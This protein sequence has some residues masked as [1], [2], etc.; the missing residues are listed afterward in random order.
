MPQVC[1]ENSGQT[2]QEKLP[3]LD[4]ATVICAR[5]IRQFFATQCVFRKDIHP[6]TIVIGS[7]V[8]NNYREFTPLSERDVSYSEAGFPPSWL[9]DRS[10][11]HNDLQV[12]HCATI[13]LTELEAFNAS[14]RN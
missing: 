10:S 2:S 8:E 9:I 11:L 6:L 13:H 3:E 1:P 14:F 12:F 7:F 5:Q 4:N